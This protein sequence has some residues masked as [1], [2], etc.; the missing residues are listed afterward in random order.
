M[1][2]EV[3]KRRRLFEDDI[4]NELVSA[5]ITQA[6]AER[7]HELDY[8]LERLTASGS[9]EIEKLRDKPATDP[10][11]VLTTRY[12]NQGVNDLT[13]ARNL[14]VIDELLN[15]ENTITTPD[16]AEFLQGLKKK[17]KDC[18]EED[19]RVTEYH[20]ELAKSSKER[21]ADFDKAADALLGNPPLIPVPASID[22]YTGGG[23]LIN[24]ESSNI[25]TSPESSET[26]SNSEISETTS[27]PETYGTAA[28][29]GPSRFRQDSSDITQTDFTSFEPGDD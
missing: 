18:M 27:N 19:K 13:V 17:I 22:A 20:V 11:A 7:I 23:D 14:K 26:A 5:S 12:L 10:D 2:K 21:V 28:N 4:R 3:N 24:P 25:S 1:E 15:E 8:K 29:S 9:Q 16:G 6:S